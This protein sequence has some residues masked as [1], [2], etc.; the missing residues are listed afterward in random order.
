VTRPVHLPPSAT[1]LSEVIALL[2][3]YL[4]PLNVK[5]MIERALRER[6]LS[7]ADFRRTDLRRIMPNLQRGLSLFLVGVERVEALRALHALCEESSPPDG[8]FCAVIASEADISTARNEARRI[9][10]EA[11]ARSF[12]VQKVSTI[13]SEL[14]RNIVSYAKEGSL[15][16]T[17]VGEGARRLVIRAVDQGPGIPDLPL[18]LSGKYKSRTGLGR[19][20]LGTQRLADSFDVATAPTGTRVTAEVHL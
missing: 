20:L 12:T 7:D 17:L 15:E 16:I 5:A 11:G 19:G 2:E 9:C 18:V 3:R 13:V 14:A 1:A 4:S 6:N 8:P 10:E